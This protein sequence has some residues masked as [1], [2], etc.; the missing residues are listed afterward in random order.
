MVD[1]MDKWTSWSEQFP[2]R[3]WPVIGA[4]ALLL[5]YGVSPGEV[6][7]LKADCTTSASVGSTQPDASAECL[8]VVGS[9]IRQDRPVFLALGWKRTTKLR[10]GEILTY[11]DTAADGMLVRAFVHTSDGVRLI[12]GILTSDGHVA[13]GGNLYQFAQGPVKPGTG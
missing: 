9:P 12:N 7:T 5:I 6:I 1:A 10:T 11:Y 2:S 13:A 3:Q 8:L 4:I